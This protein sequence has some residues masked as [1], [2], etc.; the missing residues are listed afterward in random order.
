MGVTLP[1]LKLILILA[2]SPLMCLSGGALSMLA[3]GLI[4]SKKA[5]NLVVML[6]TMP[7]MFLSGAIKTHLFFC[8]SQ[9]PRFG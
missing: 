2:L 4:K 3:I 7:Q 5:A 9:Y 6:I 1:L 8:H